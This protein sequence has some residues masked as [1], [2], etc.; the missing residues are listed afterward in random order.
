MVRVGKTSNKKRAHEALDGVPNI[1]ICLDLFHSS[2]HSL[3]SSTDDLN[4]VLMVLLDRIL[5]IIVLIIC[6]LYVKIQIKMV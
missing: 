1:D 2:Y 3:A 5:Q 6:V 4:V